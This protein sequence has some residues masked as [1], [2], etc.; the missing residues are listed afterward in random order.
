[1]NSSIIGD[2][3][4]NKRNENEVRGNFYFY[5]VNLWPKVV[6]ITKKE[7]GMNMMRAVVMIMT[8]LD[9]EMIILKIILLPA[10]VNASN[11][12]ISNL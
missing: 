1:M 9:L 8:L 4:R 2:L 12:K 7:A 10:L 5:M 3:T 11:N 6:T